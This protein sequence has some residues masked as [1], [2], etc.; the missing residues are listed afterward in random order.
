MFL[1][2]I[3]HRWSSY[4]E[5]FIQ[6]SKIFQYCWG[7]YIFS[8]TLFYFK[9][10]PNV[11]SNKLSDPAIML[12]IP[13]TISPSTMI[14]NIIP[15]VYRIW[16]LTGVAFKVNQVRRKPR[17]TK[18]LAKRTW[19]HGTRIGQHLHTSPEDEIYH[20]RSRFAHPKAVALLPQKA[21][22]GSC[23]PAKEMPL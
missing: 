23:F 17:R 11:S 22:L 1:S 18:I 2:W 13:Y 7:K 12:R 16:Y 3:I 19:G 21:I 6:S 10:R 4:K 8:F 14:F 15:F 9:E 20:T 5:A